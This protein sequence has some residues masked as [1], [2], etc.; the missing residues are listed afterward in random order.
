MDEY[1][2]KRE[3]LQRPDEQDRLLCELP[4][5]IADD[6]ET[7]SSTPD[8]RHKKVGNNFKATCTKSSLLTEDVKAVTNAKLDIADPVKPQCNSPKSIP[9]LRR[10]PDVPLLDFTKN[11]TM[12]NCTSNHTAGLLFSFSML[13]LL[14]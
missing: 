9:I 6:Q 4:Q 10:S 7:E 5:V 2:E 12:W 11:S 13:S 1:L 3:K 14:L 8:S